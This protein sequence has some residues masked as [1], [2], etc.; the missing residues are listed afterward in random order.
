MPSNTA[1][2]LT[3]YDY[4]VICFAMTFTFSLGFV[5][6]NFS[7][8]AKDYFRGGGTVMWWMVG[9]SAFMTMF[10]AWTFTGAAGKAYQ[11]GYIVAMIFY[12]NAL[13][14]F[15]NYLFSSY[16]FRQMRVDT[17]I[18]TVRHRFGPVNEQVFT[19]L[20]V[21]IG[22][23]YA[24]IWL[25]GLA[26]FVSAVFDIKTSITIWTVGGIIV[27]VSVTGGSWAIVASDFIQTLILMTISI[28]LAVLTLSH[29]AIGG[30]TGL[31]EKV[32]SHFINWTEAAR[33]GIVVPWVFAAF[34]KQFVSTNNM[35][36]SYRF[37]SVRD[38]AGARKASL[39]ACFLML[40]GPLIW[41]IPP[42]AAQVLEPNI[43]EVFPLLEAEKPG[44][45]IEAAYVY[46]GIQTLPQ[47][48]LGL[49]VCAIFAATMSSMDSGVNRN[50]GIFVKSFYHP[51][52]KPNASPRHLLITGRIVSLVFGGLI[53]TAAF[54]YASLKDLPLF[55]IMLLFGSLV[56]L[57]LTI[58]LVMGWMFKNSPP[59]SGWS[60]VIV[61]LF[62]SLFAKY[63][64][65]PEWLGYELPLSKRESSDFTFIVS[66]YG[67]VIICSG[68]FLLTMLFY[69]KSSDEY[70]KRLDEFWTQMHTPVEATEETG[71]ESK[72][73]QGWM[74]GA[75]C[76]VYGGFILLLALLIP[77]T[78]GGRLCYV[79]CG[80][81]IAF[82]G[83]LVHWSS[84][85]GKPDAT[86]PTTSRDTI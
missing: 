7:K 70:K 25:Y 3:K 72:A 6:S 5:F 38:S 30:F 23:M 39:L 13:G 24:G 10:S 41:F 59:W 60:T 86:P 16:R 53:I 8:N 31:V 12:G 69:E 77:N 61:G 4:I 21:P 80:G 63:V 26:I 55:D 83:F 82:V 47:G 28:V 2:F 9:A 32:P 36:D 46:M 65:Q 66:V 57:P 85:V 56:A 17:P 42:M 68:W 33:P 49:L 75:L 73:K 78:L 18:E 48:M 43:A 71:G 44:K 14:Y 58:P 50:A 84:R 81:V 54:W 35:Y 64:I 74:L 15:C 29:P 37:V 51:I 19:W 62:V 45:A 67:N 22:I 40:L 20:Q 11:D 1:E 76:Y 52:F 27:V 79:F 34:L